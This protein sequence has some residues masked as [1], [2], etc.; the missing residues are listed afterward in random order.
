MCFYY[1]IVKTNAASL[2]KN[3]VTDATQLEMFQEYH[4]VS[5]FGHPVM[6]VITG[7]KPGI[8][9]CFHWGY[10]PGRTRNREQAE[11]F[12][13]SYNT[14][15]AKGETLFSSRLYSEAAIKRRC[16]VL[17]S[18][19]FEWRHQNVKGKSK[20]EKYPFYITLR[21]DELFVFGGVWDS[22]TDKETGEVY[23]TYSIITT[24]ANPLMAVVHNSKNRMP[25][26]IDPADATKWLDP[27]TSENEITALI[28]PFDTKKMR[29]NPIRKINPFMLDKSNTPEVTA[30]YPY[31]ELIEI[32]DPEMFYL[33]LADER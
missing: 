23:N 32:L 31:P 27:N 19:F 14:L 29:A 2:I 9:Q 17:C 33:N 6:P 10:I 7:E 1:A 21:N 12:L 4:I 26:I 20:P 5:G 3:R 16:L 28:K 24:E 15:N 22:F 11:Q 8:V 30:Y 25:L 18:G 13:K